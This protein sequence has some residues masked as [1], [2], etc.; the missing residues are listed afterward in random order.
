MQ[1][2]SMA[3]FESSHSCD[4]MTIGSDRRWEMPQRGA[5]TKKILLHPSQKF[6]EKEEF[7]TDWPYPLQQ[8][9]GQ[10]PF[11]GFRGPGVRYYRRFQVSSRN[12][13]ELGSP[14]QLL[15][16]P[17]LFFSCFFFFFFCL[18]R[19]AR[20]PPLRCARARRAVGAADADA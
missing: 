6:S 18:W 1:Q 15:P 14:L 12:D 3:R 17:S 16:H 5:K 19:G 4:A 2:N 13:S 8:V 20:A 7:T 10:S 11:Y 9:K